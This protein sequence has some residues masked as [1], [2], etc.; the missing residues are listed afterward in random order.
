MFFRIQFRA[1][2]SEYIF[3]L[4]KINHSVLVKDVTKIVKTN[5]KI[6]HD[7]LLVFNENFE[8]LNDTI[9]IENARRY[10][11]KRVPK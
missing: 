3:E 6:K 1:A 8:R 4:G 9:V 7:N 2:A 5:F 10:I 11:V